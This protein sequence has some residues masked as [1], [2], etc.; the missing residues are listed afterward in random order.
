MAYIPTESIRRLRAGRLEEG[1]GGAAKAFECVC[2]CVCV[3][4]E[5]GNSSQPLKSD[6]GV[7]GNQG[8]GRPCPSVPT[9][10]RVKYRLTR[11]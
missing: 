1:T 11:H 5:W 8:L 9:D 6:S 7:D 10:E 4:I 2:V 3:C